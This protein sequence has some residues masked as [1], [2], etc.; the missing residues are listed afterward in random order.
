MKKKHTATVIHCEPGKIV[1]NVESTSGCYGCEQRNSCSHRQVEGWLN[2]EISITI[3]EQ[4]P[5]SVGQ[6]VEIE[7]DSSLIIKSAFLVYCVPIIILI[8]TALILDLFTNNQLII[9][10]ISLLSMLASLFILKR[11]TKSYA[12]YVTDQIKIEIPKNR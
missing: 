3:D 4:Q 1:L 5:V 6:T 8:I 12:Q 2:K 7:L 9:F 11:K 10:S